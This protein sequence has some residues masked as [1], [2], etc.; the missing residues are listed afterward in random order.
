[1][2]GACTIFVATGMF[3]NEK[4]VAVFIT[5]NKTRCSFNKLYSGLQYKVPV[6]YCFTNITTSVP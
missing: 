2:F 1:M 5:N 4:E 6:P 3:L